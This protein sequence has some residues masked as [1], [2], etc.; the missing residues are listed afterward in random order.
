M[1]MPLNYFLQEII[2]LLF[3]FICYSGHLIQAQAIMLLAGNGPS[4]SYHNAQPRHQLLAASSKHAAQEVFQSQTL[5]TPPCSGLS[6][7][8]TVSSHP[9]RQ[10]CGGSTKN[11]GL[12]KINRGSTTPVDQA[13]KVATPVQVAGTTMTQSGTE[14]L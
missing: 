2:I 9:M 7:P 6:S 12:A 11:D 3:I 13:P 5:I 4:A 10:S 14:I 8:M 1:L